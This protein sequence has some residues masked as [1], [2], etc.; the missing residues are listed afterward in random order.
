VERLRASGG[1]LDLAT[2]FELAKKAFA[3]TASYDAA[4][5]AFLEPVA[6]ATVAA[7]YVVRGSAAERAGRA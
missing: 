3:H 4:I 7:T 2:R 1:T 5:A 6:A